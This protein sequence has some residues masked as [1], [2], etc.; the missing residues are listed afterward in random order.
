MKFA[1][2]SITSVT[3]IL[4]SMISVSEAGSPPSNTIPIVADRPNFNTV[5]LELFLQLS[6]HY[7]DVL[8]AG[9][10]YP[11]QVYD[12]LLSP[13]NETGM[14]LCIAPFPIQK[15]GHYPG[16]WA[17][18]FSWNAFSDTT[19]YGRPVWYGITFNQTTYQQDTVLEYF[20]AAEFEDSLEADVQIMDSLF[21]AENQVWF[22]N[23][24]DEGPN[25]QWNYMRRDS[26]WDSA[27]GDSVATYIDDYIPNMFRQP[28]STLILEEID[29]EGVFSWLKYEVEQGD[30]AHTVVSVF[31]LFHSFYWCGDSVRYGTFEN[32]VS[33]IRAYLDMEY[34]GYGSPN[35]PLAVPNRP[36]FFI[37]DC[38]PYRL[39]GTSWLSSHSSYQ[40]QVSGGQDTLLL[41]H[42][43]EG[44]DSTFITV[45]DVAIEQERNIPFYYYP[46]AIGTSGGDIMWDNVLPILNY[47]TY[48]GRIPTPQEFLLNCNLALMRGAV[49]L[50][51]YCIR[52]YTGTTADGDSYFTVGYL[53]NNNMPFDAPYEEWVYTNRW[54]SDYD[55]IPPD[56]F[57]PFSDSCRVC[58]DF[59]PLWDLPARPTT[60][61]ERATEDYLMWKFSAYARRWNSFRNTFAQVAAIAPELTQLHWW[62][63]YAE[64]LE[65]VAAYNPNDIIGPDVR[66]FNDGDDNGYA[67]YI[68]RNCY[69][70][71]S[72]INVLL[73]PDSIPTQLPFSGNL[74]D[75]SRRFL[76]PLQIN[77]NYEY[78]FIRDTLKP[79]QGRLVQFF[80]NNLAADIRITEPDIT[81]S[82][83]G[84]LN[85]HEYR[86]AAETAITVSATFYNM[87][88]LSASDV[89]VQLKDSTDNT[90]LDTDTISF[91]GLSGYYQTDDQTVDFSWEPDSDDIGIHI[92]KIVAAAITGEPDV[93]DNST[94]VVFDITPRDYA[95]TVLNDPWSM[96]EVT[97]P[98]AP[99][100]HTDDVIS[101]FGWDSTFTDSISGMFEGTV[102][103]PTQTNRL[104]LNLGS[105]STDYIPTRLYDQFSMIARADH[106]LTATV[107]W[108]YKGLRESSLELGT[109]IGSDP[110]VIGPFDLTSS[111]SGW[112]S[113]EVKRLWLE[114][115]SDAHTPATDVRIG[116]IKL[117]E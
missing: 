21:G 89:I 112:A 96:T 67:Y 79:G 70:P 55:V 104:E 30:T 78:H 109:A 42:F 7:F 27:T 24:F 48:S 12:K 17:A 56:S 77:T 117:T 74:L 23:T 76:L 28:D 61:G 97:G 47:P 92:L 64:C 114:F 51:P 60:T 100:W 10:Q 90:V 26:V 32:Q 98:G 4:S 22:Y 73:Y 87:G 91:S 71:T 8:Q 69:D 62:E 113:E 72:Q 3:I 75:H 101:V 81:A 84:V 102:S 25:R 45:R 53:D 111:S 103:D 9:D 85:T 58:G 44:M 6:W 50:F 86:F 116:W 19:A 14:F 105:D 29:P 95:K 82:G 2:F 43:E 46:Q 37:W 41:A 68:N 88:T 39:V 52:T 5:D 35:L 99:A 108:Q 1:A 59:D 38:Y 20:S 93:N 106:P 13:A 65:A 18:R 31:G 66:L 54:R 34:Q 36:E 49:A 15:W 107:H 33:A 94:Q 11:E 115:S 80:L 16:W 83:G 40:N 110:G 57:P 63:D